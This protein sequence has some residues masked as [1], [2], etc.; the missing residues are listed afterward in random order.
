MYCPGRLSSSYTL[1]SRASTILSAMA[2]RFRTCPEWTGY[3]GIEWREALELGSTRTERRKDC[4]CML[5]VEVS[6][7]MSNRVNV[8]GRDLDFERA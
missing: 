6:A 2:G 5:L 4:L 3:L 1:S 7:T 8:L